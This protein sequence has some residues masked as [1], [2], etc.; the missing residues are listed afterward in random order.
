M[1]STA[2]V[3]AI[4]SAMLTLAAIASSCQP[5][6]ALD[7]TAR[8]RISLEILEPPARDALKDVP[9]SVGVVLPDGELSASQSGRVVDDRGQVI[10]LD[11]E[12]TGWWDRRH[13]SIKWLLLKFPLSTDRK[14]FFEYPLAAADNEQQR[15]ATIT[16]GAITV[17]TGPLQAEFTNAAPLFSR[18][19]L[20]G[21]EMLNGEAEPHQL[22]FSAPATPAKL[23]EMNW[24]IEEATSQRATIRGRGYF[25]AA[26]AER[27][28]QLDLRI[29]FFKN[30]S[31]VRIYHT[32]I[33]MVRDPDIGARQISLQIS[34]NL[35]SGGE[36][37]LGTL[38]QNAETSWSDPWTKDTSLYFHQSDVNRLTLHKG[39]SQLEPAERMAGWIKLAGKD[40]R[41]LSVTLRDAW[42]T[43]PKAFSVDDG[44]LSIELWPARSAPM[45]FSLKHL[46]PE[47]LY[48]KDEWKRYD[49]SRQA[50]HALHEYGANPHF[51]HTAEGVAR[52]HEL[53]LF[54]FDR[55]SRRSADQ[56][57]SITQQ[58]VVVRQD[59][60]SAMQV[61]LMGFALSPVDRQAYPRMEEAIDHLGRMAVG[62]WEELHDYGHWRFGMLRWG[63]PPLD[64]VQSGI[65]RWFDGVQYDLQLIPWMLF[66]RGGSRDFYVEGERA[67]R[68]AMDVCTNHY[69]TRG[70]APG[71]QGGAAISPYPWGAHHL[72]KA[73]KIHFLQYY[74]HLTGY[75]RAKDVMHEVI[76]GAIWG[77]QHDSRGP[78]HPHYRGRGREQYNVGRFWVNAY[79]ET[80][81][82]TCRDFAREWLDITLN[83][84][85]DAELGNFRSPGIYLS[86]EL[87]QQAR[88][89]PDDEKL[90]QVLLEYLGN[91]GI[92]DMLDGGVAYTNR[93]MLCGVARRMSGDRRYGESAF[94]V[95]R[96]LADLVPRIDPSQRISPEIPLNGSGYFR[97]WLGPILVGLA[98]GRSLE[99][100]ND[101]PHVS[102][103]THIGF[104]AG[105]EPQ[106]YFRPNSDGTL[107]MRIIMRDAWANEFPA[108]RISVVGATSQPEKI[109]VAGTG[110]P[111]AVERVD[112]LDA[113]YRSTVF[114]VQ[115]VKKGKT[116]ALRLRGG[117]STVAALVLADAQVVHRLPLGR[118]AALQNH[119]GQYH[120]GGRVYLETSEQTVKI[121]NS[122]R[123]PFSI[124][125]A[126]TWE[127]L[128]V[129][130]LP[131]ADETEHE[132]GTDR[133]IAILVASSRNTLHVVSGVHPW[134]AA[135]RESWFVP[136]MG[137][138]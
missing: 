77:A 63:R 22:V 81:N 21:H 128:Y 129:S 103:D 44:K 98:Q 102:H 31:Y 69:N 92:P 7:R 106:I 47:S 131:L 9:V 94:D 110:R 13:Q 84:E 135:R 88:L 111:A 30:E 138:R 54:F 25:R 118:Q 43:Y 29:Q 123:L 17:S 45:G 41:G 24:Q 59:P 55:G 112:S 101:Q 82:P 74:Y 99:I 117:S 85:Y 113:G 136:D 90:R 130:S 5:A 68:Y 133:R 134:A 39:D 8:K 79:E 127:L 87:V 91:L 100:H 35:L 32:V 16:D 33:W 114:T 12:A 107:E 86:T 52:T 48:Y 67:G 125:D 126:D 93:V 70:A 73:L 19:V 57:H 2:R 15:I 115:N 109:V 89:W 60:Q 10:P 37:S 42:Q 18:L 6:Q 28:A 137:Q 11:T 119:A 58:P 3:A 4:L 61:P 51:E 65:Y 64:H 62:R 72:H 105:D 36:I 78:D 50:K 121:R 75:P 53:T 26:W 40:G 108:V 38:T 132:L 66:M 96:S 76:D 97:W 34:P 83:R 20:N 124:R 116:Y 1:Q 71:Y 104:P 49:W 56:L 95:A 80:F 122:K 120:S 14:Y 23:S 46:V 27:A